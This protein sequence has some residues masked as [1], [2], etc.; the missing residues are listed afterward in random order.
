MG[1]VARNEHRIPEEAV[2][3]VWEKG[4]RFYRDRLARK[5][6][7]VTGII[8]TGLPFWEGVDER[9]TRLES[10][11]RG[12]E[13]HRICCRMAQG[14]AIEIAPAFEGYAVAF[15][16]FAEKCRF[17]PVAVEHRLHSEKLRLAGTVDAVCTLAGIPTIVDYTV[18]SSSLAKRLQTAV[19]RELWKSA[20]RD[21]RRYQRIEVH[22]KP[23]GK[24]SFRPHQDENDWFAFLHYSS[25]DGR[26]PRDDPR[27]GRR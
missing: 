26:G 7:S 17:L 5:Y 4:E 22:L 8:G 3:V 6:D 1:V 18:G 20:T 24:F 13:V 23:N 25:T 27:L 9:G 21:R 16:S 2:A 15:R 12:T 19:Y 11:R 14:K 10:S